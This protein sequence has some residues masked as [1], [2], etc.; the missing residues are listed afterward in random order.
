MKKTRA[1]KSRYA[2]AVRIEIRSHK[3]FNFE[4]VH[5][6]VLDSAEFFQTLRCVLQRGSLFR[7]VYSA[8]WQT[9]LSVSQLFTT[10]R[11]VSVIYRNRDNSKSLA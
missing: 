3:E 11:V 8:A 6:T 4:S 2:V 5:C 7:A 1:L 9:P 10:S